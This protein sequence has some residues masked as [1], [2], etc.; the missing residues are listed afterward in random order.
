[1]VA[2]IFVTIDRNIVLFY[3]E[4]SVIDAFSLLQ[5]ILPSVTHWLC[6][7]RHKP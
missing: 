4:I 3:S 5:T 7:L 6:F 1:M 2:V